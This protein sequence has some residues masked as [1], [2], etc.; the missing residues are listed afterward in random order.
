MKIDI[1]LKSLGGPVAIGHALGCKPQAVSQWASKRL[2]PLAR[3]PQLVGLA[4]EKGL[5]ILPED[6]RSDIDWSA[7]RQ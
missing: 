6:I 2:V 1:L 4:R 7:L 3:V 5:T